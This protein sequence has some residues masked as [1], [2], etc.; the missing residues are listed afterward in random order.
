VQQRGDLAIGQSEFG[1]HLSFA[2]FDPQ[3]NTDAVGSAAREVLT[4]NRIMQARR[5]CLKI[6]DLNLSAMMVLFRWM[7]FATPGISARG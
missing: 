4:A 5:Y 6:D 2:R 1:A 7:P 3:L